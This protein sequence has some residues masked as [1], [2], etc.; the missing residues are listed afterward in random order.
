MGEAREERKREER[1]REEITGNLEML[2]I[3][4]LCCFTKAL[5][6]ALIKQSSL[7]SLRVDGLCLEIWVVDGLNLPL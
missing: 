1:G 4:S 3:P 7:E 2:V 6:R 5:H